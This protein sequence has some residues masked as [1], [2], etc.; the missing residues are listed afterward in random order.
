MDYIWIG[1]GIAALW[2]L[3]KFILAPVRHL[4]ANVIFGLVALY[5]INHFGAAIGL[6]T[7]PI[8]WI[9]GLIIGFFGLPGV[10]AV[11]LYYTFV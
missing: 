2:I 1:A 11:T 3:N 4:A 10:A 6:H 7:V 5:F 8:T 9:T